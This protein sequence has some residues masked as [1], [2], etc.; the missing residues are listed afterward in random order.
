MT[1]CGHA[2]DREFEVSG[3]LVKPLIICGY[4]STFNLIRIYITH[5]LCLY[6]YIGILIWDYNIHRIIIIYHIIDIIIY[7]RCN[8]SVVS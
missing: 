1:S 8:E 3:F 5:Y 7:R 6:I 4:R 2:G